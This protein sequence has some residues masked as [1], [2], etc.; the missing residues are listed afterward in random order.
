[1]SV[2]DSSIIFIMKFKSLLITL[3]I[4]CAFAC[5]PSL[6]FAGGGNPVPPTD[7][8]LDGGLTLLI[9]AGIGYGAKKV[10]DKRKK[11]Q[12]ADDSII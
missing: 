4:V 6:V 5:M 12:A 11:N 10:Y 8:P 2:R 9:A 7:A 1:M 3:L